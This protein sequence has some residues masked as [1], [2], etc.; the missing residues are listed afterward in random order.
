MTLTPIHYVILVL[1]LITLIVVVALMLFEYHQRDSSND[2]IQ[3]YW[4]IGD[5]T[6]LLIDDDRIVICSIDIPVNAKRSSNNTNSIVH[7]WFEGAPCKFSYKS[8]LSRKKHTYHIELPNDKGLTI[9]PDA[10]TKYSGVNVAVEVMKT[11]QLVLEVVP[12]IGMCTITNT[13]NN[14]SMK[15]Y[16]EPSMTYNHFVSS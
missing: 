8:F 2:S 16:K 12:A 1:T 9:S 5:Q 15:C 4:M 11:K 6:F 10:I 7:K 13:N 14:I 3:G